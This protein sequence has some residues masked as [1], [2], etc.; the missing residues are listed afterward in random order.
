MPQ[1]LPGSSIGFTPQGFAPSAPHFSQHPPA[2][3]PPLPPLPPAA[4]P[5]EQFDYSH[6]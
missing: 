1:S 4:G 3:G 6:G 2:F 5:A